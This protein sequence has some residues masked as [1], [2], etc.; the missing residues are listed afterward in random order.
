MKEE[1]S[2]PIKTK[3]LEL[4]DSVKKMALDLFTPRAIRG[5]YYPHVKSRFDTLFLYTSKKRK[6][7]EFYLGV[8]RAH[9]CD[10]V[11]GKFIPVP[12]IRIKIAKFFD[13]DTL[14]IWAL[15]EK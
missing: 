4:S 6:D 13:T 15:P 8:S 11:N 1:P 5:C 3:A 14:T 7:L 2:Q 10:I 12:A 9:V